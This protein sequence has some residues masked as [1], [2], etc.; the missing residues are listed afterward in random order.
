MKSIYYK[1]LFFNFLIAALLGVLL[2]STFVFPIEGITFLYVLHAHSHLALLGWLYLL[3]YVLFAAYFAPHTPKE[4]QFYRRLFWIT[5]VAV[6]GMALTFPFQGYAAAS[7]CF[8]TLHILCSYGFVYRLWTRNSFANR[9]EALLVKSALFF[10]F[11]STLGVWFLGPAIGMMGK[12]GTFFQLCIQFFLHF[13]FDGWFFT[14]FIALLFAKFVPQGIDNQRFNRFYFMWIT[15]V[16]LTY[17][18]A[19]SWFVQVPVLYYINGVGVVLQTIALGYFIPPLFQQFRVKQRKK[20]PWVAG[21]LLFAGVCLAIRIGVQ[22]LT[23]VESLAASLRGL[24]SWIVGFIHLNMLGIFTA[25]G[26]ALLIEE[27]KLALNRWTKMGCICLF[28]GFVSTEAVLGL[29][30]TQQ[31]LRLLILDS[32]TYA[33]ALFWFS[34]LLPL[35]VGGILKGYFKG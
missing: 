34:L 17:A 21:L 4:H 29:Q 15:S 25:L 13:Q 26:V 8:S 33:I 11:F 2:R 18:L 30:G 1:I 31:F 3:V 24:R 20:T 6:I 32:G 16:L 35:G 7:I 9:Q 23:L 28:V 14:A 10:M 12:S 19:V 22:V 5:Q 27:G